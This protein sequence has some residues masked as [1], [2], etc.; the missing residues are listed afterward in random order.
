MNLNQEQLESVYEY[1]KVNGVTVAGA[2]E[3]PLRVAEEAFAQEERD[4]EN[5][6]KEQ[7]TAHFEMYMEEIR[8][9]PVLSEAESADLAEKIRGGDRQAVNRLIEGN[10]LEAAKLALEYADRGVPVG[11][12][13]QEGN[14]AL[15]QA[16]SQYDGEGEFVWRDAAHRAFA[17]A[18]E[19]QSGQAMVGNKIA[20]KANRLLEISTLLA[21]E[22]GREA[23]VEEL[24]RK[25]D[26][27][28]EEVR[29]IMKISLN[30]INMENTV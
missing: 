18:V 17:R 25:L 8:E 12:L 7:E 4:K 16:A 26:W 2:E 29:E 27:T 30:V 9:V 6:L 22:L 28:E 15:I 20:A 1:L 5:S 10:L 13:I 11:D 19:T 3:K 23:T 21:E 14:M 24:C